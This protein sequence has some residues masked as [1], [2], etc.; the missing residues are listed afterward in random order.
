MTRRAAFAFVFAVGVAASFPAGAQSSDQAALWGTQ[1]ANCEAAPG[2]AAPWKNTS[3]SAECRARFVLR[4]FRSLDEKLRFL[5]PPP[6]DDPKPHTVRD[7]AKELGLPN[8]G[9]SDGPAGVARGA[10]ATALPSPMAVGASFDPAVAASYGTVLGREFRAAG[11]GTILGPAFDIAR[12]WHSGRLTESMGEDPFLMARMAAAEVHA[13]TAQKVVVQMKHY[14][15][16]TQEAGRVGDQPSGANPAVSE[17]ISEKALREI[18][19]PAFEAAVKEGGAGGVMCS[20]PRINGIYSCENTHLLDILKREWR[21]DGF[22]GPDFPSGQRSVTRAVMAGLDSGSFGPSPFDAAL[23]HEKPLRQ[24]V[25][26]GDIPEVR[27]DDLILRKLI[28]YFRVGVFDDPPLKQGDDVSSEANRATAADILAAGTVLLKNQHGILPFGADVH[29]VA[30]I[31]VQ[32][33]ETADVVELG[34]PYVAP[35]HLITPL[36]A[37]TKRAGGKIKVSYAP[38]TLGTGPL[39][40]PTAGEFTTQGGQSGFTAEYFA[41]P[42]MDFAGK[43]LASAIVASPSLAKSPAVAGLPANNRWSVRYTARFTPKASGIHRFSLHG[44]GSAR[45][46]I[47]GKQVAGFELADFAAAGFANVLLEAGKPIDVTIE[48][49]PRSALRDERMTMFGQEMGLTLR[50]GHT[51][52][53]DLIAHAQAVARKADVAVVFAGERVGEGMDR[54]TLSLQADQDRL[55]AAVA[56]ANPNTV[57]VL[58]TGGP[59]AMPWLGRVRGVLETW[60]PGDAYGTAVAGMLFGDREPGGRLPVTFP[61]DTTQGPATRPSEFPGTRDPASGQLDTVYFNEGPLVG[62][63]YYDAHDQAPLFPFGYGLSYGAIALSGTRA[64]L[65]PDGSVAAHV[66]VTNS[67]SRSG[68]VVVQAYLGFPAGT[69]EPPKQLK[70]FAKAVLKSG[71]RRE[72]EIAIPRQALRYWDADAAAWRI[73][74]GEYTVYLGTSSRDIAWQGKVVL[75]GS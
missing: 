18:Y 63:R 60:M 24:A 75:P 23:A 9:G 43:A 73:A 37:I 49:S 20:F 3:Y 45:L 7:V 68:T 42:N 70:G 30:L 26:D 8:I 34:S 38:G 27:I 66:T 54:P 10:V 57:V 35:K 46:L 58:S 11:L 47:D 51:A 40:E 36:D 14:A 19:L 12:T 31:G 28:P 2:E 53:D 33:G 61:A 56:E 71:E 32:A 65:R 5:D 64:E 59:A 41:D 50:F 48:Y 25:V 62:Y 69:E 22:V 72:L 44:S 67:G 15:A 17:A 6:R 74:G 4:Q 55:I 21:F 13:I 29:S 1:G 39:P 52:P 16:Y